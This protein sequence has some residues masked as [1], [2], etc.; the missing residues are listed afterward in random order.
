MPGILIFLYQSVNFLFISL[1]E[2][3]S[4]EV[5]ADTLLLDD[6]ISFT[7]SFDNI[8]TFMTNYVRFDPMI[9]DDKNKYKV[10]MKIAYGIYNINY[11]EKNININYFRNENIPV[12]LSH[13]VKCF[14][15]LI[16]TSTDSIEHLKSFLKDANLY[17]KTKDNNYIEIHN[18]KMHWSRLNKLP[19][20]DMD[21]IYL[22]KNIKNDILN[23]IDTFFKEEDIYSLYGIPYKKTYLLE[24]LPG[25]GKTSLIF[26]IA[27]MLKMNIAIITFGP[28]MDDAIFMKA[29]SYLPNNSILLLEDV[30]AVFNQRKSQVHSPITFSALLNT[31][32]GVAR[33]HKLITFITTNHIENLDKALL[34]PGRI[35]KIVN[36]TYATNEQIKEMFLKFRPND[37]SNI[38]SFMD[39]IS[40]YKYTTAV[41]QKFFFMNR[42]CDNI[43]D[44][45]KELIQINNQHSG[46]TELSDAI[47][48]MYL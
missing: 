16:L 32:D 40:N 5:E 36:F 30:D 44:K 15:K 34:R 29:I 12:G 2:K 22:D 24:G 19:I 7:A 23:D 1:M 41:L 46:K 35:D 6:V 17:N 21:T 31:L 47:K 13:T 3:Y 37:E 28:D 14:D 9:K 20:R 43:V 4:I 25:T 18:F 39:K 33:R 38:E 42:D 48:M 10:N 8:T 45:A 26:A 27:S 11:N